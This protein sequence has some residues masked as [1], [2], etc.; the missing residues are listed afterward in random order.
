MYH[1]KAKNGDPTPFLATLRREV[2]E[3]QMGRG[4][5]IDETSVATRTF[6]TLFAN[7]SV[8]RVDL[9]QIDAE[10]FDCEILKLF[11]FKSYSPMI[12]RFEH[13]HLSRRELAEAATLLV[14]FGYQLHR[15]T[16]DV[17]AVR[18]N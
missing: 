14:N 18:N 1:A 12:V 16:I 6:R 5:K 10:G 17:V 3:C 9:L 11:D 8:R 7:H 2:L 13:V 15:R 4:A